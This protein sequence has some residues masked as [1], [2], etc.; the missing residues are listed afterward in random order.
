MG[1]ILSMLHCDI[2]TPLAAWELLTTDWQKTKFEPYD[3]EPVAPFSRLKGVVSADQPSFTPHL[4]VEFSN[5]GTTVV[6]STP[7][8]P[9]FGTMPIVVDVACYGQY[10][11][12]NLQNG[13]TAQSSLAMRLYLEGQDQ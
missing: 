8:V 3:I 5:D 10:V 6:A 7:S 1:D 9:V 11:R 2:S 4:W 13:A 12:V